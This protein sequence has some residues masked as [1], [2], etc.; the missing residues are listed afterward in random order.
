MKY[1]CLIST[2]QTLFCVQ[3]FQALKDFKARQKF[4][5][6][7]TAEEVANLVVFLASDEVSFVCLSACL[8]VDN[9]CWYYKIELWGVLELEIRK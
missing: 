8:S 9:I 3:Y 4:G 2:N 5:R 1:C 7:C 6:F